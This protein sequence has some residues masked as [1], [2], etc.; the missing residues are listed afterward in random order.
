MRTAPKPYM[1]EQSD[2]N[3]ELRADLIDWLVE[4]HQDFRVVEA[5]QIFSYCLNPNTLHL[6][7][8]IIDRYCMK[9]PVTECKLWLVGAAALLVAC[10]HEERYRPE[11]RDI[12]YIPNPTYRG[13]NL[14]EILDMEQSILSE[15]EWKISVPTA[16]PFLHR[17]LTL[18]NASPRV[19]YAAQ[20]YLERSLL[21]HDMLYYRPSEVCCAAV[22]L[23]INNPGILLLDEDYE[24]VTPGVV[25]STLLSLFKI[26]ATK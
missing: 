21:E 7:V 16:F 23:A 9:V 3:A 14:Q 15:L 5:N 10:K 19:G 26:V 25:S 4:I 2:I 6:C 13:Y 12:A 18:L 11:V 8:N 17:F 1:D 24:R 22:I 20:Y